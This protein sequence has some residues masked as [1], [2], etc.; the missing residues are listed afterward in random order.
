MR[1][2]LHGEDANTEDCSK[3]A[4]FLDVKHWEDKDFEQIRDRFVTGDWSKAA[5]RN[6]ASEATIGDEFDAVY[7]DFEDLEAGEKYEGHQPEREAVE[8]VPKG[9]DLEAEQ[10]RLKKLAL[11]AKFDAQYPFCPSVNILRVTILSPREIIEI[12][13]AL[14]NQFYNS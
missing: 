11:R 14:F 3:T 1:G 9:E 4:M 7:G 8:M 6:Q 10:R 13:V 2:G 12:S 5:L